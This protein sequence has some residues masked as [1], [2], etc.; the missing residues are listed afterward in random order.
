MTHPLERRLLPYEVRMIAVVA[1]A[2]TAGYGVFIAVFGVGL[3]VDC[4]I[5]PEHCDDP[6]WFSLATGVATALALV[7]VCG[8]MSPLWAAA[9]NADRDRRPFRRFGVAWFVAL[10]WGLLT[11]WPAAAQILYTALALPVML[12]V[13]GLTRA[14]VG[15]RDRSGRTPR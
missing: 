8:A 6:A 11:F 12:G 15:L 9:R 13:L 4:S 7:S 1:L 2:A 10:L 14:V 3:A 5:N